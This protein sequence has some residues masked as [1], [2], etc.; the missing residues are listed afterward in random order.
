MK[1]TITRLASYI[2]DPIRLTWQKGFP[3][4]EFSNTLAVMY[5]F[6]NEPKRGT[7]EMKEMANGSSKLMNHSETMVDW[8]TYIDSAPIPKMVLPMS[9]NLKESVYPPTVITVYP[10]TTSRVNSTRVFLE[11]IRSRSVPP[12]NG[13]KV[14]GAPYKVYSNPNV[15]SDTSNYFSILYSRD[16]GIS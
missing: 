6:N 16:P 7:H 10:I 11:P 15:D 3:V 8:P 4:L 2:N 13:I 5:P 1:T 9:I 14:F 12:I